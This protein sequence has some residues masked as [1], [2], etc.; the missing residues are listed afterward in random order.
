VRVSEE[1]VRK[2]F[3]GHYGEMLQCRMIMWPADQIK[4]ALAD[5]A[6][7]R[8]SEDAFTQK[9]K[10]QASPTLAAGAGRI[11]DFGRWTLD[12]KTV[13]DEAF[14]LQPGEISPLIGTPA[15][16]VVIKCD[17]RIPAQAGVKLEQVRPQMEEEVRARN[18]QVE[19]GLVF[20]ELAKKA[21]PQLMLRDPGKPVDLKGE[22]S[23]VLSDLPA[24]ERKRL[25]LPETAS[26]EP[27]H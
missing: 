7:I 18:V 24:E 12:D 8:D 13:E 21:H 23:R 9:A 4:F 3:E 25:G 27:A 2:T 11:A 19:M 17:R 16:H 20:G 6:R 14:K 15:G 10:Q 26:P 1:D 22:T 5:Y